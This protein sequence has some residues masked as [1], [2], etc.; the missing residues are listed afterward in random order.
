M[1]R[2]SIQIVLPPGVADTL[3]SLNIV[4]D[5]SAEGHEDL[6]LTQ[7]IV[8]GCDDTLQSHWR[9]VIVD[10]IPLLANPANQD[11][12]GSDDADLIRFEEVSGL[13]LCSSNGTR[14]PLIRTCQESSS[15]RPLRH[16]FPLSMPKVS[17]F[18]HS[19]SR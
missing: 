16:C 4:N 5:D 10:S 19:T 18:R 17:L 3:V 12:L 15:I 8:N 6:L 11:C 2:P 13:A 1:K 14:G 7:S 9:I